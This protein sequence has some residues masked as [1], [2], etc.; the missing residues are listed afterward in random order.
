VY[1]SLQ[2]ASA[3]RE[4]ICHTGCHPAEVTL[5]SLPQPKLALDLVILEGCKAELT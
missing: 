3:L 1:S 4:L 5:Q 2:L